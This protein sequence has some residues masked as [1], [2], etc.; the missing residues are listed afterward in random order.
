MS[1]NL[2]FFYLH[3]SKAFLALIFPWDATPT[4]SSF[5]YP[6]NEI[7][8]LYPK[9]SNFLAK[10][11]S[12]ES[13]VL[14][15]IQQYPLYISYLKFE[16][17]TKFR[18]IPDNSFWKDAYLSEAAKVFFV[19]RTE[20]CSSICASSGNFNSDDATVPLSNLASLPN[21]KTVFT[22]DAE[23]TSVMVSEL[24]AGYRFGKW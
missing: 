21:L 7:L 13:N 3:Q 2:L 9:T 12:Q 17:P 14:F 11:E 20:M 18:R 8:S 22:S 24:P 6:S 19:V 15:F 23:K 10:L 1:L 16:N 4:V 5:K